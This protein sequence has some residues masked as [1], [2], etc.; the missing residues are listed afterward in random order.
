MSFFNRFFKSSLSA[1]TSLLGARRPTSARFR[2][3]FGARAVLPVIHLLSEEQA[4]DEARIAF[5]ADADG[6][7]LINH[8]QMSDAAIPDIA[9]SIRRRFGQNRW[10]G[11]NFLSKTALEAIKFVPNEIDGLWTDNARVDERIK[12]E[13]QPYPADVLRIQK[14]RG[15]PGLYFGGTAFKY[16]RQVDDLEAAAQTASLFMDAITTSGDG[17]GIAADLEKIRRMKNALREDG[18][19]DFPLAIASGITPE[20]ID[21]YLPISDAWLV[22][23]GICRGA[24]RGDDFF[25]FDPEKVQT[26]IGKI[27]AYRPK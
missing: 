5:D 23:T 1:P 3:R 13:N 7:F 12:P 25:R 6:V 19:G 8:G 16:Q 17:T 2:E 18:F 10:I 9:A 20:N 15:W 27:K 21:Q 4:L 14:E 24:G 22:A 26:L 11:A